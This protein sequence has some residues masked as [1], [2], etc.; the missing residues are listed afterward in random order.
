MIEPALDLE[1]DRPEVCE[2]AWILGRV[3][4]KGSLP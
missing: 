3:L 4:A 2:L 1:S